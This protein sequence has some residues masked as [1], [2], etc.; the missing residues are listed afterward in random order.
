MNPLDVMS[1]IE[2]KISEEDVQ[3]EYRHILGSAITHIECHLED[4]SL[5]IFTEHSYTVSM[6][7]TKEEEEEEEEETSSSSSSSSSSSCSSHPLVV[8]AIVIR[9]YRL[10]SK[11]Q[12]Q[13]HQEEEEQEQPLF[14][15]EV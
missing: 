12:Q 9:L 14:L 5:Q 11:S 15:V 6:E 2:M 7:R 8:P 4:F 10:P 3:E 13:H 1:I